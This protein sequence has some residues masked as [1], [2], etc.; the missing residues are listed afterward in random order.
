MRVTYGQRHARFPRCEPST[1]A[2]CGS[3]NHI[4][5]GVFVANHRTVAGWMNYYGRFHRSELYPPSLSL[6]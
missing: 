3:A 5:R 1:V 2:D 6:Q 4:G